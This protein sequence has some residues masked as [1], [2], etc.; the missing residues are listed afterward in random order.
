MSIS[1]C[2]HCKG[3]LSGDDAEGIYC[4][5]CGGNIT[6]PPKRTV[7]VGTLTHGDRFTVDQFPEGHVEGTVA[8]HHDKGTEVHID[9]DD[10]L[11]CWPHNTEVQI[12]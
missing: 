4:E 6:R 12:P 7:C 3:S 8:C 10:G 9:G 1:Q 5:H 2:P 11:S